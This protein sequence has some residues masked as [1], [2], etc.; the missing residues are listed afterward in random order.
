MA[1]RDRL[2]VVPG[3]TSLSLVRQMGGQDPVSDG[4]KFN[5][6]NY[7]TRSRRLSPITAV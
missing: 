1:R 6:E 3:V 5:I 2:C 4:T 7:Q